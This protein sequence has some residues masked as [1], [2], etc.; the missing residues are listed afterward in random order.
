MVI[1]RI[2][3]WVFTPERLLEMYRS[4]YDKVESGLPLHK[5]R[6]IDQVSVVNPVSNQTLNVVLL[7]GNGVPVITPKSRRTKTISGQFFYDSERWFGVGNP[8]LNNPMS[9]DKDHPSK[10]IPNYYLEVMGDRAYPIDALGRPFNTEDRRRHNLTIPTMLPEGYVWGTLQSLI[11]Y[12]SKDE[13]ELSFVVSRELDIA[14]IRERLRKYDSTR[15]DG[16]TFWVGKFLNQ[17]DKIKPESKRDSITRTINPRMFLNEW[18]SLSNED[19]GEVI[20][21]NWWLGYMTD[22]LYSYLTKINRYFPQDIRL[23]DAVR[24]KRDELVEE[25]RR[26]IEISE[27]I[28]KVVG[29]VV[30]TKSILTKLERDF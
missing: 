18:S 11:E 30:N 4:A 28:G 17:I 1:E 15:E 20:A 5:A 2:L 7:E 25:A 26:S 6:M 9:F 12:H 13:D 14:Q 8:S 27:R 10:Y 19:K 3:G 29:P 22:E 23:R 24:K 21:S 16:A